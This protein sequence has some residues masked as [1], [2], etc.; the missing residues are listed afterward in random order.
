MTSH[1]YRLF[2]DNLLVSFFGFVPLVVAVGEGY[3]SVYSIGSICT[4]DYAGKGYASELLQRVIHHAEQ[5][6]A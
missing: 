3:L 2:T 5:A 1:T 6:G 4:L